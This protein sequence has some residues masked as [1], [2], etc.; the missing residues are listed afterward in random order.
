M[1]RLAWRVPLLALATLTLLAGCSANGDFGEIRPTLVRDDV[2]DW[3]GP[4]ATAGRAG[5]SSNFELTDDERALRDL[6]YPL[7]EPPY[8]RQQWYSIAG[9]YGM[10]QNGRR[11]GFNRAAY[12]NHLLSES[13]RSPSARYEKLIDNIRDDTTR[14][15]Q[16]FE[17]AGRVLDIDGK[18]RKSLAYVSALSESERV[19][20]LRRI[21]ENARIVAM[22]RASLAERASSYRFALERLV[23]S[24]PS[25]QAVEAERALNQLKAQIARYGTRLPP[26]WQREKSLVANN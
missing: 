19:N 2:H 10:F 25:Q 20:A 15:P 17:T 1:R 13:Y 8:D 5:A 26:T 22:V 23:I 21:E 12:A 7:I 4:A 16:F 9:E 3:I 14:L 11:V 24:T 18:R 6:A